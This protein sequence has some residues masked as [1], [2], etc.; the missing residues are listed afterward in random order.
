MF[1]LIFTHLSEHHQALCINQI[2]MYLYY[3]NKIT[4]ADLPSNLCQQKAKYIASKRLLQ[5]QKATRHFL[6]IKCYLEK[7]STCRFER[8]TLITIKDGN[9]ESHHA[10]KSRT[11]F[12]G[13]DLSVDDFIVSKH[14]T[15]QTPF[16]EF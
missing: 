2:L 9:L 14:S 8:Q 5:T 10:I 6:R 15:P 12:A 1:K 7:R 13:G 16:R 11:L 4:E 3:C